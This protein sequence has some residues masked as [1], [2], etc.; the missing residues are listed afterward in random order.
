VSDILVFDPTRRH[1]GDLIAHAAQIGWLP[2]PVFD[3]TYGNGRFWTVHRPR[4]LV[5]NDLY[6]PADHSWD[7]EHE[8][9]TAGHDWWRA[10][11]AVVWDPPYKLQ[12]SPSKKFEP[13]NSAYGV[14]LPRTPGQINSMLV[15]GAINCAALVRPGGFLLAKCQDQIVCGR[16]TS[17]TTTIRNVV[18]ALPGMRFESW[19]HLTSTARPQRSQVKPRNNY[20]TLLAFKRRR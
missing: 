4:E 5:T 20:S 9:I 13:M 16:F 17:Q 10:F 12:G 7:W 6:K 19:L 11:G 8:A 2:E 14:D 3:A 15:A 1:N 18:E